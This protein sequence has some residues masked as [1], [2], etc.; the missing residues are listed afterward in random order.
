MTA[1]MRVE[2]GDLFI[3]YTRGEHIFMCH[4]LVDFLAP[5][6]EGRDITTRKIVLYII[7]VITSGEASVQR[8]MVALEIEVRVYI[9][10]FGC[11]KCFERHVPSADVL[12]CIIFT[13]WCTG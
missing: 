1:G 13:W 7:I 11:C 9:L 6:L 5:Q 2:D 10:P 3:A 8:Y 4:G 12:W